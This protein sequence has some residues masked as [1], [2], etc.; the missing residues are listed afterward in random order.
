MC[1]SKAMIGRPKF[2][3]VRTV[4]R[5]EA[6]H[7]T[8]WLE[9]NL[10]V[11]AERLGIELTLVQREKT[12]GDFNVDLLCEDESGRPVIVENQL[13][14]TDHDH[15]G[16]LLTYLV[17]LNA[18]AAIWVTGDPRPEHEKV[19]DWLNES[20][21]ADTA[22]YLVKVEAVRIG[23]SSPAPLFTVIASPDEQSRE[24]GEKKKEWADRHYKREEFW[25]GLLEKSKQ[26]TRLFA[27]ISPGRHAYI[28]TGSG[29]SG[30]TFNYVILM[31]SG[32][33]ELYIDH[34][35]ETGAGN[36]AIFDALVAQKKDIEAEFGGPLEWERLSEKRASRI[37]KR[38]EDRGLAQ[39]D[40]WPSLQIDM[41][42][43]MIRLDKALR[44]RLAQL[45]V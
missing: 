45:D 4:F 6:R 26:R 32:A 22:F 24:V 17:N 41:L 3:P 44:N 34:D 18:S 2:E 11:L 16:K 5:D 21:G 13:E 20:T 28:A 23:E 35:H 36:K 42:E 10:E 43:A 27:T 9:Q 30:V 12:V 14:K 15:L 40:S 1:E 8:T 38:F 25:K 31:D 7:F 19:I 33:S 37:R 39:P 29:K